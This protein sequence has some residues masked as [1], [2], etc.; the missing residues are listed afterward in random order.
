MSSRASEFEELSPDVV[1]RWSRF[2]GGDETNFPDTI[3]IRLSEVRRDYCRLELPFDQGL[4]QP[5][6][7]VHGGALATLIDTVVVPAI[8]SG[9]DE[10]KM[11]ATVTMN[12]EYR[13]AVRAGEDMIAEG[14]VTK[15]GRSI[16]FTRAEVA[17]GERVVA[18]GTLVYKVS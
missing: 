5:A 10:P 14:W 7:I 16:V 11:F 13:S 4:L 17:V 2:P 3:G 6:G 18:T 9:F 15:R 1:E 8:G 12:I